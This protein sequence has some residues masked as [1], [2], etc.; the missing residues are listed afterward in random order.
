MQKNC[1][2]TNSIQIQSGEEDLIQ[3]EEENPFQ[4]SGSK[5]IPSDIEQDHVIKGESASGNNEVINENNE[6]CV[7][8]GTDGFQ[9]ST[10]TGRAKKGKKEVRKS[11]S[12]NK[13]K[14][15]HYPETTYFSQR[16]KYTCKEF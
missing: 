13:E 9:P 6:M 2:S 12:R 10:S 3:S 11:E 8:N 1:S 7:E 14:V 16:K 5:Y 4:F 15:L